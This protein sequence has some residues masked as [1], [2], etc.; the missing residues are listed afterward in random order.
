MLIKVWL[1]RMMELAQKSLDSNIN[2]EH[3]AVHEKY[4][5]DRYD[6]VTPIIEA[7]LLL[8]STEVKKCCTF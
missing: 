2:N 7:K 4:S 5:Y 3:H 8:A 6:S 1:T